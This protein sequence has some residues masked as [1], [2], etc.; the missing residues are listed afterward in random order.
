MIETF[1]DAYVRGETPVP[2]VLCNQTVKFRDLLKTA[3]ELQ[4]DVLA[5]GHYVQRF[6]AE[7]GAELHRAIDPARDQSYFLFA[8]TQD[9]A[10]Y[11]RF[12]LGGLP[13]DECEPMQLALIC[14][15][16]QNPTARIFVSCPMVITRQ[17]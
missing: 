5:T 7:K 11:L 3:K 2:C 12:P 16:P 13:K 10:D 17:S 15:L 6:G 1:A 9:Q 14:R 4:G 8:T